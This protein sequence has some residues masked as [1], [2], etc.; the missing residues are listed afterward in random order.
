M[1][2]ILTNFMT[3]IDTF[4]ENCFLVIFDAESLYTNI[5]HLKGNQSV[6]K[7]WKSIGEAMYTPLM[8]VSLKCWI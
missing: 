6:A 8:R 5:P 2:Q 3:Q 4:P 7:P 1:F